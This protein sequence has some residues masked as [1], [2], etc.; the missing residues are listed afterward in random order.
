[1]LIN[2]FYTHFFL[3]SKHI[4][5]LSSNWG[6]REEPWTPS[7]KSGYGGS[8]Y[9]TQRPEISNIIILNSVES[10]S[11]YFSFLTFSFYLVDL[12]VTSRQFLL[13]T[14][15]FILFVAQQLCFTPYLSLNSLKNIIV[16][17]NLKLSLHKFYKNYL[18]L[19]NII[20]IINLYISK[21]NRMFTLWIKSKPF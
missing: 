14:A 15:N 7:R 13:T 16:L 1:M 2:L 19:N 18:F 4:W 12:R 10:G 11:R 20:S 8:S 17:F 3:A 5:G 21:R 6:P 9:H